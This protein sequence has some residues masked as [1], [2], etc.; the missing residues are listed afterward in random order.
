MSKH[1]L[2]PVCVCLCLCLFTA[3]VS[4][5]PRPA[6]TPVVVELGIASGNETRV[7][8]VAVNLGDCA[9]V[10]AEDRE[11]DRSDDISVCAES[12]AT[13]VLVRSKWNVRSGRASYRS[14]WSSVVARNGRVELTNPNVTLTLAIK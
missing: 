6:V 2:G 10:S 7:Y 1:L 14:S 12:A 8:R 9:E 3:T 4:A 13:G 5:Q 11:R